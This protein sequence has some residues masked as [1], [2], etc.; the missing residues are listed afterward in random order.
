MKGHRDNTRLSFQP[1][2]CV[3]Y[4]YWILSLAHD[5]WF[6][7]LGKS[8]TVRITSGNFQRFPKV[9][10]NHQKIQPTFFAN[11]LSPHYFHIKYIPQ[12][13]NQQLKNVPT[14][15]IIKFKRIHKNYDKT[16]SEIYSK[17]KWE[18]IWD[19]DL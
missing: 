10:S 19:S 14:K 15:N 17:M 12:K 8:V 9:H 16:F 2:L 6:S 11:C 1:F 18:I 4:Y 7:M 13:F 5:K 3:F